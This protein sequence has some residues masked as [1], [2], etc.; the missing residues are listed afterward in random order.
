MGKNERV[1]IRLDSELLD[2][3][4]LWA[5]EQQDP[6]SRSEALRQLIERGLSV[7]AGQ[8]THFTP[9]DK[10]NF[11]LL[12]DLAK[13]LKVNTEIN[14]DFMAEVFYGGHY[15]APTWEMQGL[16]HRHADHPRTVEFV[17]DVLDMWSFLEE[18]FEK[19]APSE[20]NLVQ[21]KN[22]GTRVE[23]PGF[24]GNHESEHRNIARFLIDR[25]SRF[26]RFKGRDLN[27]HSAS[28]EGYRNMLAVFEPMRA[29]LRGVPL[30]A[31][32]IMKILAARR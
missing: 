18:G 20:R 7:A 10:L 14:L 1:E 9:G 23:F 2:K 3:V 11:M 4:E 26:E 22:F 21:E 8:A 28:V 15:W 29:Q 24:D 25:M 17:V 6:P 12:R 31:E 30:G 13:H 19:L 5:N 32:Q 27:S 16:F